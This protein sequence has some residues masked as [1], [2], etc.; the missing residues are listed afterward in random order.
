MSD[1]RACV[2]PQVLR[3]LTEGLLELVLRERRGERVNQPL[4]RGLL[5]M[6]AALGLY[7]RCFEAPCLVA[8]RAFFTAEGLRLMDQQGGA[9][10]CG[11]WG[12]EGGAVSSSSSAE[13]EAA[14]RFLA[15]C[16]RRLVAV[17]AMVSRRRGAVKARFSGRTGPAVPQS[18]AVDRTTQP[19]PRTTQLPLCA[20]PRSGTLRCPRHWYPSCPRLLQP[21]VGVP[22]SLHAAAAAG[23]H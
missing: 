5:G 7:D 12:G 19:P 17:G 6:L 22:V 10:D 8:S 13:A 20:L 14:G 16:E 4:A 2:V 15:H 23:R 11:G 1:T 21:G 18:V 9:A 3:R